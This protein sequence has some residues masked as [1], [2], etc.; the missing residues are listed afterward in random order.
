MSCDLHC[1]SKLSDGSLDVSEILA[2]A[3][4]RGLTAISITDHD[5][6]AGANRAVTEGKHMG[7]SVIH[8]VEISAKDYSRNRK[9]HILGYLCDYPERLEEVCNKTLHSRHTSAKIMQEKVLERYPIP[10]NLITRCASES[11]TIYKQHMMHALKEAGYVKEFF[12]DTFRQ[13]FSSHGGI[14]YVPIEYPDVRQ[15]IH[16]IHNAGGIAVLAH[17]Y[18]YDSID[19]MHEL[20]AEGLLD[21]IEV[22]HPSNDE[23]RVSTLSEYADLHNLVKTGGTDFH[24][25]YTDTPHPIGYRTAP[26]D[27]IQQLYE[28]KDKRFKK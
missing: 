6:I 25:M 8:G 18:S 26:D 2:L 12:G 22:W 13:L 24:G 20:V 23:Q 19:L 14:A 21:G 9:V 10:Q 7:V 16:K 17:P 5:T 28:A 1:H 15:A 3:Q 4:C 27:V 11:S